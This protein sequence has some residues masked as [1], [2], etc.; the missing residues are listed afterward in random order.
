MTCHYLWE[1]NNSF[2]WPSKSCIIYLFPVFPTHV[3]LT[4]QGPFSVWQHYL[5]FLE[6]SFPP[7]YV[8]SSFSHL[9]ESLPMPRL[10]DHFMPLF[11]APPKGSTQT[12]LPVSD[13]IT[14]LFCSLSP[15]YHLL[16]CITVVDLPQW[17]KLHKNKGFD[18]SPLNI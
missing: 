13:S 1:K 18:F 2:L 14:S 11:K 15:L 7:L 16:L 6:R 8:T 5:L 3:P 17:W 10:R 4:H 9:W 12:L